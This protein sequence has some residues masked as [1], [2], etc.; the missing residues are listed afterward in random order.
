MSWRSGEPVPPSEA[1]SWLV[2][3]RRGP[4]G[5]LHGPWPAPE[6]R[7]RRTLAICE[8][9]RSALVVAASFLAGTGR[10]TLGPGPGSGPTTQPVPAPEG[11]DLVLRPSGGGAVLVEP[12]GQ[13]WVEVWLPTGDP[14]WSADVLATA[15]PLGAAW[16]EALDRLGGPPLLV[17]D[18][19]A[20]ADAL[21]RVVCFAG[22]GPGEV[23]VAQGPFGGRKVVGISQRRSAQG[24]RLQSMAPWCWQPVRVVSALRTGLAGVVREL[25]GLPG[26]E[27][28][29]QL[30]VLGRRAVGLGD[31][32]LA[33]GPL[34]ALTVA[35][36][37]AAALA[38]C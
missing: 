2:E 32:G 5:W 16:A 4:A 15:L 20:E 30:D 6:R 21:G 9:S 13:V 27:V 36:A 19:R 11:P 22:R 8:V 7:T 38:A 33:L 17:H 28:A 31:L 25:P 29:D 35:H 14:L 26:P 18:G 34:P 23:L 1:A 12:G 10:T 3:V 37:V 24:V